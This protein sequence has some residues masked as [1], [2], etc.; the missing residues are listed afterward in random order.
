MMGNSKF[1]KPDTARLIETWTSRPGSRSWLVTTLLFAWGTP[2]SAKTLIQAGLRL[3][4]STRADAMA[5]IACSNIVKA[6]SLT[7]H[8]LPAGDEAIGEGAVGPA[9]GGT[10][11]EDIG[12]SDAATDLPKITWMARNDS[13]SLRRRTRA[14]RIGTPTSESVQ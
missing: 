7:A 13:K 8:S 10:I 6:R 3:Y 4:A 12:F 11:T 14:F 9:G 5:R 1:W 2:P